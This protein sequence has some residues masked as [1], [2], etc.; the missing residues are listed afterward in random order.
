MIILT[1]FIVLQQKEY[2]LLTFNTRIYLMK[3]E[4][5]RGRARDRQRK[6][7][8]LDLYNIAYL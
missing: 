2:V 4:D 5:E 6:K 8:N 3:M 1:Q 7:L